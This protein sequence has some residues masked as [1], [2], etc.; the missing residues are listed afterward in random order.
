LT[1]R[2]KEI[3]YIDP[4]FKVILRNGISVLIDKLKVANFVIPA[5]VL[6]GI[7]NQPWVHIYRI[8]N[9]KLTFGFYKEI[10]NGHKHNR[11]EQ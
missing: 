6:Q 2:K 1:S 10:K 3:R 8:V 7:I 5:N 4:I 11:E 9:R